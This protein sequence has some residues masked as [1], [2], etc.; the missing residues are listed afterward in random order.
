[1]GKTYLDGVNDARVHVYQELL[2]ERMVTL[3]GKA[4]TTDMI[5]NEMR[6]AMGVCI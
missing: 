2:T 6:Y 5:A 4:M 3:L 1:M